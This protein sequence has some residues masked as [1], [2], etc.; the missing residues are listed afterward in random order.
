M[1]YAKSISKVVCQ[2]MKLAM[3]KKNIRHK[4]YN[5]HRKNASFLLENELDLWMER[6]KKLCNAPNS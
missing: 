3:K 2:L 1:N 6:A 4:T 5:T